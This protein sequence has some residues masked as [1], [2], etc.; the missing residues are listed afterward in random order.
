MTEEERE[1]II[2]ALVQLLIKTKD[3]EKKITDIIKK[4]E[5]KN[6]DEII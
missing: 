6:D 1:I 4:L 2:C 3:E 5:E